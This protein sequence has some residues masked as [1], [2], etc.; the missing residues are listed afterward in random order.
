MS[1]YSPDV[2]RDLEQHSLP[3]WLL[4]AQRCRIIWSNRAGLAFWHEATVLDLIDRHF[5]A[6]N[7]AIVRIAALAGDISGKQPVTESFIFQVPASDHDAAPQASEITARCEAMALEDGRVGLLMVAQPTQI[8]GADEDARDS[9]FETIASELPIAVAVF[10]RH[11]SLLYR[12]AACRDLLDDASGTGEVLAQW[13]GDQG[14]AEAIVSQTLSFGSVSLAETMHTKFGQRAQRITARRISAPAQGRLALL[15]CFQD[16]EDRRRYERGLVA[17]LE[18]LDAALAGVADFTFELDEDL[19][20][21]GPSTDLAKHLGLG[22]ENLNG[23]YWAQVANTACV[24]AATQI[25]AQLSAGNAARALIAAGP[26]APERQILLNF[27]PVA[28]ADGLFVGFAGTG[29]VLPPSTDLLPQ[30]ETAALATQAPPEKPEVVAGKA[31][32]PT[33]DERKPPDNSMARERPAKPQGAENEVAEPAMRGADAEAFS[34]I[35]RALAASRPGAST[36]PAAPTRDLQEDK[37]SGQRASALRVVGGL[38]S[39]ASPA[40]A[41]ATPSAA[42]KSIP[43]IDNVERLEKLAEPALV[44]RNFDIIYANKAMRVLFGQAATQALLADNNLLNLFPDERAKLFSLQAKFDDG[45]TP[46]EAELFNVKLRARAPDRT[47]LTIVTSFAPVMFNGE[48]GIRMIFDAGAHQGA[49]ST[50]AAASEAAPTGGQEP[51][52]EGTTG[53][54]SADR[55]LR[56]TK[57]REKEL[58]AVINSA[59]DGIA[60]TDREGRILTL[61]A[62]GEAIFGVNAVDVAGKPLSDLFE[63]AGAKTIDAYIQSLGQAGSSELYSEGCEVIGRHKNGSAPPLFV[64]VGR[65]KVDNGPRFC[66]VIRDISQWKTA[67]ENLRHEKELAEKANNDKSDFLARV[68]HELRTP[69]NAII[70]FSEVMSAEKFGPIANDRYKGYLADIHTSGGHLLSLINDLLDLS[71]IES[72]NLELNFASVDVG[73]IVAQAIGLLEPQAARE[74]VIIRTSLPDSLPPVVADDRS[75][76]QIVLN[77]VSNAI[78]FT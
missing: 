35:A 74:R 6:Q 54:G 20:L 12:N 13:L 32:P 53:S 1:P 77:L 60:T 49:A 39:T 30:S 48:A 38:E 8:L 17:R 75:I 63:A 26:G 28:N 19:R 27:S 72:G 61:N 70:G 66:V 21:A 40:V 56:E 42:V 78:K 37:S 31:A 9:L 7:P 36:A 18:S 51:A 69:L 2:L 58:R 43:V 5:D 67:Q 62:S 4:D 47:S 46:A 57:A 33:A 29:L 65:M 55:E 73:A 64:T 41:T 24:D 25:M 59:A 34:A 44:H 22:D 14:R 10:D 45:E 50:E 15:M 76:R 16:I 3:A 23:R 68:S 71:K 52:D 11:G